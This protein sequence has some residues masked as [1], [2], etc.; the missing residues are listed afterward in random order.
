MRDISPATIQTR[1]DQ[2][3]SST[4]EVKSQHA[5]NVNDSSSSNHRVENRT[6]SSMCGAATETSHVRSPYAMR[7]R[8]EDYEDNE[9]GM[10]VCFEGESKRV[11]VHEERQRSFAATLR[12]ST[13][14]S[15][16]KY[17]T[18]NASKFAVDGAKIFVSL[19][20]M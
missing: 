17:A 20:S 9:F 7:V 13:S 10:L 19:G 15:A 6:T 14:M 16:Y 12:F 2:K 8:V 11:V 3:S 5:N 18:I 1:P 4:K